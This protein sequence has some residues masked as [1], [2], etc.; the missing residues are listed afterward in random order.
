[1]WEDGE[2]VAARRRALIAKRMPRLE[3]PVETSYSAGAA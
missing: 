2:V 1:M 3:Q